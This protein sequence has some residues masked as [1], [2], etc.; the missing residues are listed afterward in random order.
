MLSSQG[1]FS[2]SQVTKSFRL[3]V[4]NIYL[5]I[6]CM[7]E[8]APTCMPESV[9]LFTHHVDSRNKFK[10]MKVST[11][12]AAE[13]SAG[14]NQSLSHNKIAAQYYLNL[15]PTPMLGTKPSAGH[16][17]TRPASYTTLHAQPSFYFSF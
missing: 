16:V 7:K 17:H 11:F 15:L 13:P 12:K 4:F 10:C 3:F 14:P 8:T 9:V 1:Q 6:L 2:Q 5:S